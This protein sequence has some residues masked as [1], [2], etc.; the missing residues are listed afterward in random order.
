MMCDHL[1]NNEEY[2]EAEKL[3]LERISKIRSR[4]E[5]QGKTFHLR[6]DLANFLLDLTNL[7]DNQDSFSQMKLTLDDLVAVIED[8]G[9]LCPSV[10]EVNM[11][12]ARSSYEKQVG[13]KVNALEHMENA[14][15]LAQRE[16]ELLLFDVGVLNV[17]CN[18]VKKGL[19][20]LEKYLEIIS[21]YYGRNHFKVK[22][23]RDYVDEIRQKWEEQDES[24]E[25]EKKYII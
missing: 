20:Q 17:E 16:D 19:E 7:Y 3:L 15:A 22:A 21:R 8:L 24:T 14:I 10:I 25:S 18:N 11:L 23:T 2:E 9:D 4:I 12:T 1:V 13:S 6:K 5:S